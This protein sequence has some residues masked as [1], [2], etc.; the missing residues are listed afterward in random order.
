MYHE[1]TKEDGFS[2][3]RQRRIRWRDDK[4]QVTRSLTRGWD[5]FQKPDPSLSKWYQAVAECHKRVEKL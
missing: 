5:S 4:Q 3:H 1:Q 2:L